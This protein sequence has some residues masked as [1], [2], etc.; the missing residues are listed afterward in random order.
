MGPSQP[1][2]T[3]IPSAVLGRF[4][5]RGSARSASALSTSLLLTCLGRARAHAQ[6]PAGMK[7]HRHFTAFTAIRNAHESLYQRL[8]DEDQRN[9]IE[10][11]ACPDRLAVGSWPASRRT[12]MRLRAR[13]AGR[14]AAALPEGTPPQSQC[15]RQLSICTGK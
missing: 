15:L 12:A 14:V 1:L 9:A 13:G 11:Y 2:D 5:A 7:F 10:G 8:F 3:L 4:Q 6:F